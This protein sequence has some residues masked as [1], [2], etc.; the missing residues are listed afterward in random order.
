MGY[1]GKFCGDAQL[2]S[3]VRCKIGSVCW[4]TEG[5]HFGEGGRECKRSEHQ[6]KFGSSAKSDGQTCNT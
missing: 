2:T 1:M 3:I 5:V 6:S 4:S